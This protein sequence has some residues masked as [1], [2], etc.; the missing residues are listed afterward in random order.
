MGDA[1]ELLLDLADFVPGGAD[2]QVIA[3]EG[4]RNA[5]NADRGIDIHV[6]A[7]IVSDDLDRRIAFVSKIFRAP[8]A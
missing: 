8:L 6:V 1:V 3:G 5:G 4:R 7:E 2:S